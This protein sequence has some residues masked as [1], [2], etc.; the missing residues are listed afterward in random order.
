MKPENPSLTEA[1]Q[2]PNP[3]LL[4]FLI[5]LRRRL[6]LS[7]IVVAGLFF[8]LAYFSNQLYYWLALPLLKHLPAGSN[9]I[10]TQVI[11]PIWIPFKF[12]MVVSFLL[13]LPFLIYQLWAFIAP[14]LYHKERRLVWPLLFLTTALFYL[15]M[16][17]AYFIIFPLLFGF[18]AKSA[19]VQVMVAPDISQYLDFTLKMLFVFGFI[20]E[21]P[22]ITT[23]L[24]LTGLTTRERLVKLRPYAIV[25]AFIVGMLLAPPDVFSQTLLAIPLWFLFEIGLFCS[26]FVKRKAEDENLESESPSI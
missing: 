4:R 3:T 10:A 20:F 12:A 26:R 1:T 15:G 13:A 6:L 2:S 19:P 14:A 21:V 25:T 22:M 8:S 7:V 24:V 17:F 11:A 18:L 5:E 23:L 9:L 16:V